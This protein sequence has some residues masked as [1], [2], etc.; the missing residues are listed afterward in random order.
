MDHFRVLYSSTDCFDI[1]WLRMICMMIK[2]E[3]DHFEMLS[4][5]VV[6]PNAACNIEMEIL[7]LILYVY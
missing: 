7:D 4:P 2:Y 1:H 3:D 6:V 5:N